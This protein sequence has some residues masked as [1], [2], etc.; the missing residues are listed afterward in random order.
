MDKFQNILMKKKFDTYPLNIKRK[1]LRLRDLL[2]EVAN[3]NK[4][5]NI[6]ESLK[7]GQPSFTTKGASP[8]R[9][10]WEVK[11]PNSYSIYFNC[12]TRLIK[13]F[14]ELFKN[15]LTFVAN[16][17]IIFSEKEIVDVKII[18]YI[19]LLALTYHKRK[20]LLMLD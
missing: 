20:H 18:K 9:I 19:F 4:I 12:N 15:K 10:D 1:L 17:E 2:Y 16:R 3:E 8:I 11:K 5:N 6:E 7:W 13:V 14:R